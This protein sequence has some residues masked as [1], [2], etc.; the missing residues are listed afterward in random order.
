MNS[1]I[2]YQHL[3]HLVRVVFPGIQMFGKRTRHFTSQANNQP[4]NA[5]SMRRKSN[6]HRKLQDQQRRMKEQKRTIKEQERQL[7]L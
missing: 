2:K 1:I 7:V 5:E 6:I 3:R 4:F